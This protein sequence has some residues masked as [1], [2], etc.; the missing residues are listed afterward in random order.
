MAA[1]SAAASGAAAGA[2]RAEPV[3]AIAPQ[4]WCSRIEGRL[5]DQATA[6]T[7]VGLQLAATTEHAKGAMNAIVEGVRSELM[8]FKRQVHH[9]HGQ[10]N[11]VVAATQQKFAE[12]EGVVHNI[13][14]NLVAKLAL[15]DARA[16]RAEQDIANLM[17]GA[18]AP[19]LGTPDGTPP[20]SPR[21]RGGGGGARFAQHDPWR[22]AD[23]WTARAAAAAQAPLPAHMQ[24]PGIAQAP[25]PAA[26]T[27]YFE[28]GSPPRQQL[29]D[30]KVDNRSWGGSRRL[31]LVAA[32]EAFMVLRDRALGHLCRDRP[33]VRRLL[34]WA[35]GRTKEELEGGGLEAAAAHAGVS[36]AELVNYTLFEGIKYTLTDSLLTRARACDGQGVELWRRLHS[37]W[38]GSA[39]QLKH[40]KVRKFQDPARCKSAADLWEALPEWE[41]L[42]EEVRS[43]GFDAPDW[44]RES[45]LEKLVP[46]EWL[47]VLIGRP[48]LDTYA[49]K[50]H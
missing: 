12:V 48:E 5:D 9:D 3:D 19:L 46:L 23:P 39:P 43:A 15:M 28:I 18:G 44:L 21:I 38:Q 2:T 10:M 36:D 45:A 25:A 16:T 37:E 22:A 40:A 4:V 41:R 33:D 34:V 13:S 50:L 35:E 29:R 7:G 8:G 6:V 14:A 26:P 49:R 17:A 31:D 27:Q 30:F 32:P 24:P 20:Q 1:S 47:S 42:G 11:G